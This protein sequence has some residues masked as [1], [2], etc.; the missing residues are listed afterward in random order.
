[1]S[2]TVVI[3]FP[4]SWFT[5]FRDLAGYF[6]LSLVFLFSGVLFYQGKIIRKFINKIGQIKFLE[7]TYIVKRIFSILMIPLFLSTLLIMLY[8][9]DNNLGYLWVFIL[10]LVFL[11]IP[12]FIYVNVI[13]NLG[14]IRIVF[15]AFFSNINNYDK[16]QKWMKKVF[17]KLEEK[18]RNGGILVSSEK[19]LHYC[20]LK[21]MKSEN[22]QCILEEIQRWMTGEQVESPFKSISLIVPEDEIGQTMKTSIF[23]QFSQIPTDLRKYVVLAII[24]VVVAILNPDWVEKVLDQFLMI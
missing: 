11:Y 18:L 21:L 9:T 10:S 19:L 7:F 12:F 22:I 6:F 20:N 2:F 14:E 23:S 4:T 5:T 15:K 8:P 13:S 17:Q 16:R 3:W 24:L 1:M